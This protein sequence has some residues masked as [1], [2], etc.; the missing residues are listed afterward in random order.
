M[1]NWIFPSIHYFF[2]IN[3]Y[4]QK[5]HFFDNYKINLR[6]E[7][8]KNSSNDMNSISSSTMVIYKTT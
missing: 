1:Y 7:G 8:L 2:T 6:S 3:I 4:I 5:N